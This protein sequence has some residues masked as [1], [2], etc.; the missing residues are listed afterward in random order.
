MPTYCLYGRLSPAL[1]AEVQ[2]IQT[3]LQRRFGQL[4]SV[5]AEE[6]H[7]TI[8]FGPVLSTSESEL[9]TVDAA[10]SLYP[11]ALSCPFRET[12]TTFRGVSHFNR[13]TKV[14]LH[15]EFRNEA[16]TQLQ[17]QLR[18]RY[19]LVNEAYLK[20]HATDGDSSRAFPPRRWLHVNVVALDRS[21]AT[22]IDWLTVEEAIRELAT[23]LPSLVNVEGLDVITAVTDTRL[24]IC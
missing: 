10:K 23:N 7:F 6:P 15:L 5:P 20:A 12:P 2:Y 13:G 17:C 4:V 24:A 14:F 3:E 18:Q 16:L 8:L 1:K 21:Y 11:E 9:T 19:P 22:H